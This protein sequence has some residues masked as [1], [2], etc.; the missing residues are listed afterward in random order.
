MRK[1]PNVVLIMTDQQRYDT[2]G[3]NGNSKIKTPN[4]DEL[5]SQGVVF[6]RA[7]SSCPECVPARITIKT[8]LEPWANGSTSNGEGI[9]PT[10][11]TLM[12]VLSTNGYHTQAIGKMH[13]IPPREP[14]GF[15]RMWLSEEI[16][17]R[18]ED[19]EFLQDLVGAGYGHAEEPHGMRSYMYYIPQVSQLPEDMH[20][21]AWTGRKSVEYLSEMAGANRPFF[22]WTSFIKPHPPFDPPVPYNRM[23]N[24]CDMED[25]IQEPNAEENYTFWNYKQNR[26]KWMESMRDNVFL[27]T[28]KAFYYA[29]ISFIDK[30]IGH[31]L[32]ALERNGQRDNTIVIFTSD[33]GE[34]LGDHYC[35]GKRGFQDSAARV[36][37]IISFPGRLPE[38]QR[39][40]FLV[41]HAD[42]MPTILELC[43]ITYKEKQSGRSL[44]R[45]MENVRERRAY[46]FGQ[47]NRREKAV[48]LSMDAEW[49]YIY[50]VGG[51][52]EILYN[53]I[54]DPKEVVNRASD[55]RCAEVKERLKR[56]L[57]EYFKEKGNGEAIE[58]DDFRRYHNPDYE[59]IKALATRV[60]DCLEA[61]RLYQFSRWNR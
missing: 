45:Q 8:G 44:I 41:G 30:Q 26:Y 33:H 12:S 51:K 4:L 9:P 27:R 3:A 34:Y 52:R 28:Q 2:I 37:F 10:T 54:Q 20:T 55:P 48:Y 14:F 17:S 56:A 35:F 11:P 31:I 5:S 7:Y 61:G 23:Y 22:L 50:C 21:T 16:P 24:P 6:E 43:G 25:P 60:N 53:Y 46:F 19:D 38:G 49:K 59:K 39:Y 42:I 40:D 29:C 57:V 47:Y 15:D 18:I 32:E 58:G 1:K 13:F 36:P